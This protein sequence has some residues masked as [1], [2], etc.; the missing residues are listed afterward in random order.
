KVAVI[1]ICAAVVVA[2][3]V[4]AVILVSKFFFAN[5]YEEYVD[6][7]G[8]TI[9]QV[10][11][12]SGLDYTE[13][14]KIYKLPEDRPENTS[15]ASAY[16]AIPFGVIIEMNQF[17][18]M[19]N[20]EDA[21]KVLELPDWVN[22]NTPWGEAIGEAPLKAYVGEDNLNTFKEKYGL[23]DNITGDTRYKEI[24]NKVDEI[25]KQK[26]EESEKQAQSAK[27]AKAE[28]TQA[29]TDAPTDAPTEAPAEAPTQAP[30]AN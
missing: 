27:E 13:F 26:R 16:N 4:V 9:G 19:E 8:R 15:E 7:T 14:L 6:V 28:E 17:V 3:I 10:A 29:P 23:G 2:I 5:K 20:V 12:Q 18:G 25:D 1:A 21:K 22:E 24:K 30:A 11:E